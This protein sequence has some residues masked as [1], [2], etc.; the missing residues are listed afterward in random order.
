MLRRDFLK[1]GIGSALSLA[2][3]KQAHGFIT[4][5]MLEVKPNV[6]IILLDDWGICDHNCAIQTGGISFIGDGKIPSLLYE[7]PNLARLKKE[8]MWFTDAYVHPTCSPTRASLLTGKN[9]GRLKITQPITNNKWF[10]DSEPTVAKPGVTWEDNWN[11]FAKVRQAETRKHMLSGEITI[12]EMLN[13]SGYATSAITGK[14][15]LGGPGY[16]AKEQGFR[17]LSPVTDGGGP[18]CYYNGAL[19]VNEKYLVTEGQFQSG[20]GEFKDVS[21]QLIDNVITFVEEQK[22]NPQPWFFYLSNYLVHS[23]WQALEKDY[24]YFLKKLEAMTPSEKAKNIHHN[25]VYAAMVKSMDDTLGRLLDHFDKPDNEFLKENTMIL[26]LGDNGGELMSP[27][28]FSRSA[29]FTELTSNYPLRGGKHWLYE[30]GVRVPMVVRWPLTVAAG[31]ECNEPVQVEDIFPTVAEIATGTDPN[32]NFGG[33]TL[34]G[35]SFLHLLKNGKGEHRESI[36]THQP[37]YMPIG[38]T[39]NYQMELWNRP[40]TSIRK[41][42]WKMIRW[43]DG[44]PELYN[45]ST[46]PGEDKNIAKENPEIVKELMRD[47]EKWF[48]RTG[49]VVPVANPAYG[50]QTMGMAASKWPT[51]KRDWSGS[52]Y[53]D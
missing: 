40:G 31:A 50:G 32:G 23:P 35:K 39:A 3:V 48:A 37:H 44:D 29:P 51:G 5:E 12:A 18:P 13:G 19:P 47:I 6:L 4:D 2:A 15:H 1:T 16:G 49:A 30:G 9:P 21:N 34:D 25:A 26:L 20:T 27:G 43:Y 11:K 53:K 28:S 36:I 7:T 38:G 10:V 42:N 17:T 22:K 33:Q 45:L 41:G 46:D 24:R 52:A 14:W 8:G